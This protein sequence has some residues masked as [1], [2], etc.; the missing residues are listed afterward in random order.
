MKTK[1][2]YELYSSF[3]LWQ[4]IILYGDEL[5]CL[6]ILKTVGSELKIKIVYTTTKKRA[7]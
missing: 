4:E 3:V 6:K 7:N 1:K 5:Q 2:I